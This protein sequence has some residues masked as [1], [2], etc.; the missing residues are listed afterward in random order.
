MKIFM[1]EEHG[2]VPEVDFLETGVLI[3][4]SVSH[5]SHRAYPFFSIFF[6]H[7]V[8]NKKL[9]NISQ[10][11]FGVSTFQNMAANI[12]PKIDRYKCHFSIIL[13]YINPLNR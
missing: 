3:T 11:Q 2:K 9:H 4:D 10:I 6:Y 12:L 1:N 13:D 5:F 7:F 8:E